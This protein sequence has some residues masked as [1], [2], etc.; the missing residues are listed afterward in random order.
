[1]KEDKY[2]RYKKDELF[3]SLKKDERKWQDAIG[4]RLIEKSYEYDGNR[5]VYENQFKN[6]INVMDVKEGFSVLEIGCGRGQLIYKL[7]NIFNFKG[8][9][10]FGLD[11]SS[12]LVEVKQKY[13]PNQI[14]WIIADGEELP[15]S[16]KAFDVI[17]YNGSLHHLPNFDKALNETF[18][19]I[20]SNGNIILY[21]PVSTVFS[22][23]IHRLI[24][25]FVFKKTK[26]ESPV[27]IYCKNSFKL[28]ALHTIITKAGFTYVKSWHDFLSYPLTGCYAGSYFSN[29]PILLKLFLYLE[30]FF[31]KFPLIRYVCNFIS[32][33]VLLKIQ[34]K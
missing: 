17:V 27:D 20:R 1:M 24:D 25:P 14:N 13:P 28:K 4:N 21:E 22:R 10:L 16:S 34:K 18:R 3:R 12:N 30:S 33:R 6:I 5:L 2:N 23:T 19:I 8:I 32:W 26:Y 7:A 31:Q 15:F 11:L 9:L 29:T